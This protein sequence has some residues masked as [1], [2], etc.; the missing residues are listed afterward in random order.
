MSGQ[1]RDR[2]CRWIRDQRLYWP[3]VGFRIGPLLYRLVAGVVRTRLSATVC[4]DSVFDLLASSARRGQT[5][6]SRQLPRSTI[7]IC[8]HYVDLSAGSDSGRLRWLDL[9]GI[10]FFAVGSFGFP[11]SNLAARIGSA[12]LLYPLGKQRSHGG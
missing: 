8:D 7:W 2:Q 11:A 6:L 12:L 3:A 9:S 4:I 10:G 5:G 1:S